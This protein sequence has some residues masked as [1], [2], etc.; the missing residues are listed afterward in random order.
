MRLR[1]HFAQTH[2]TQQWLCAPIVH[3]KLPW[4]APPTCADI[5]R[6]TLC[7]FAPPACA[8]RRLRQRLA[9]APSTDPSAPS[10]R[11]GGHRVEYSSTLLLSRRSDDVSHVTINS[12]SYHI[13]VFLCGSALQAPAGFAPVHVHSTFKCIM[14][15]SPSLRSSSNP[16]G[17]FRRKNDT[18]PGPAGSAAKHDPLV[19]VIMNPQMHVGGGITNDHPADGRLGEQRED[20][21]GLRP[22]QRWGPVFGNPICNPDKSDE[23][24]LSVPDNGDVRKGSSVDKGDAL[25]G[26]TVDK[27]AKTGSRPCAVELRTSSQPD[28]G[29]VR[30]G[31]GV[32]KG[33]A[34][35]G[36]TV[37][38]G[39]ARVGS[40][41]RQRQRQHGMIRRQ[42]QR[43]SGAKT[44]SRPCAVRP[45]ATYGRGGS[46]AKA[47][48][49]WSPVPTKA[50][51][52]CAPASTKAA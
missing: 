39:A 47:T 7:M 14:M 31:S 46:P 48:C 19:I 13:T 4:S 50:T 1:R 6:P 3:R 33:D 26:S 18:S 23:R 36:S 34:L 41:Y 15:F 9:Q 17:K 43:A 24:T 28:K 20:E 44:G 52:G 16:S 42:R 25:M 22:G 27:G 49:G 29:D 5:A 32:D 30:I 12:D 37:D 11:T 21:S 51:C 38:K 35:M 10:S 8:T 45:K 2:L 40:A